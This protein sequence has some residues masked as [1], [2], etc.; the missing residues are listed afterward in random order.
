M[1]DFQQ[2]TTIKSAVR[3][4]ANPIADV[5]VFNNI[6]QNV[7]LNNPFGCI[8]YMMG[9]INHPPVEKSRE[10]YT[11][12]FVYEDNNAK[13]VGSG[14]ESYNTVNGFKAG[15]NAMLADAA[16]AA[17]HIGTPARAENSDTYSVSLRCHAPSG[18]LYFV[19]ISRQ[20]VVVSSYEDDAIRTV[21]ETWA[22]GV[23]A[24]A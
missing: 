10:T 4:L 19:T 17:A 12:K 20:Q 15:I 16:N 18:E 5:D 7:I 13:R 6:V 21:I 1:A 9:G 14:S 11:A 3:K 24:L 23:P 8:S 22:D 2:N